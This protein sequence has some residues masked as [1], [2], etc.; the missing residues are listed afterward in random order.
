MK[1]LANLLSYRFNICRIPGVRN[2]LADALSRLC[3]RVVH[4]IHYP[5]QMPG[6]QTMSKRAAL[7]ARLLEVMDTIVQELAEIG[8][9]DESYV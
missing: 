7:Y 6:I 9:A 1:I 3:R 4:R 8:V 2:R 5:V